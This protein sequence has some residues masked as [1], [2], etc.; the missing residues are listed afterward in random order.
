MAEAAGLTV[1]VVALAGVF[2]DCIDLFSYISAARSLGSDYEL[3]QMMLDVEKTT[4]LQWAERVRL[5]QHPHDTRRD[6]P[7]VQQTISRVLASIRLLLSE[8]DQIQK[9]YAI[10]S[11]EDDTASELAPIISGP[12]M[13]RFVSEFQAL[14]LRV[15]H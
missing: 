13:Q 8:S 10:D 7:Q 11:S 12:R 3:L 14:Q 1:G 9:R 4:L 5:V 15:Q 6:E 2:K